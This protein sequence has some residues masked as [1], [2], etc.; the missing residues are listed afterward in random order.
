MKILFLITRAD[1][2]GGANVH[3]RDMSYAL[4][5]HGHEVLV[6]TGPVGPFSKSLEQLGIS[7]YNCPALQ[8]SIHPF[9]DWKALGDI[10]RTIRRYQPDLVSAHSSKTGIIGRIASWIEEVP[11]IFTAHGWAFT[12]GVPE[13]Q[14][15]FYGWLERLFAP[16]ARKIICVS[17]ND[18]SIAIANGISARHLCCIHNGMPDIPL[19]LRAH[20]GLVDDDG[21]V[22]LVMVARFDA[23]KDHATLLHACS[24]LHLLHLNF[25]GDGPSLEGM[26]Y[27]TST[28]GM[29]DRVKFL[30]FRNEVSEVI[31]ASHI[32]A[33]VS[34]WEGFPLTTLEAM[35]AGL[36]VVVSDVGGA[37]E[38]VIEGVTG[39]TIP[40]GDVERLRER[41]RELVDDPVLR[42]TMGQAAR[43]RYESEFTF[44]RMFERNVAIYKEV[45]QDNRYRGTSK[46]NG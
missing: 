41:L 18:L 2:I 40:L 3:V 43:E 45:F 21:V 7:V 5:A 19:A 11:C 28:L 35:R 24:E 33:L 13:I 44:D 15:K 8:R 9:R 27:L 38:A 16:L 22:R 32:F 6:L 25:V 23:P 42:Q 1:T 17:E 46:R 34:R 14:R 29:S 4:L 10:R 36:P 31:A 26:R 20:P 37:A 39:F 30:G 12:E